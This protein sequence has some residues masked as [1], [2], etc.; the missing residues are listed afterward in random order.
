ME[1]TQQRSIGM[2]ELIVWVARIAWIGVVPERRLTK[3]APS[4]TSRNPFEST[5]RSG[6]SDATKSP[7][8]SPRDS[9]ATSPE[10]WSPVSGAKQS[11]GSIDTLCLQRES[12]RPPLPIQSGQLD[13]THI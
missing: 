11:S 10:S 8:Q 7:S 1:F 12:S 9:V 4:M 13:H 2:L 5:L 3:P 6:Q